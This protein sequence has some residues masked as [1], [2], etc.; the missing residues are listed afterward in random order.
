MPRRRA[1]EEEATTPQKIRLVQIAG[2]ADGLYGLDGQGRVF[3]YDDSLPPNDGDNG[4]F[5]LEYDDTRGTEEE[6]VGEVET[7]SG[8]KFVQIT[9]GADGLYAFDEEGRTYLYDEDQTGWFQLQ[10][11]GWFQLAEETEE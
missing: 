3:F 11:D 6:N 8:K 2:G 10:F 5:Q 4:W 7:S 1:K 9:G